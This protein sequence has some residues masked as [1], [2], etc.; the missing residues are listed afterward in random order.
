MSTD[1]WLAIAEFVTANLRNV[2]S[3]RANFFE[4]SRA[5]ALPRAPWRYAI[6]GEP[7]CSIEFE[8]RK[9]A[10][11]SCYSRACSGGS[12]PMA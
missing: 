10:A 1:Q 5:F 11:A 3:F 9:T 12:A 2:E 7:C 4:F 6:A 8:C